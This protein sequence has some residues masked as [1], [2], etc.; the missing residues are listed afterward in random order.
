MLVIRQKF[1]CLKCGMEGDWSIKTQSGA[2]PA[3]LECVEGKTRLHKRWNPACPDPKFETQEIGRSND[4]VSQ[5][6]AQTRG[7]CFFT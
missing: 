5:L 1:K 3:D 2:E 4:E 6:P 7:R